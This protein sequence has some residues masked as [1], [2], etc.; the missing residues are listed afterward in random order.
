M[1]ATLFEVAVTEHKNTSITHIHHYRNVAL[2]VKLK[3]NIVILKKL[4]V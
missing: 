3:Y 2:N 4:Y 1:Q